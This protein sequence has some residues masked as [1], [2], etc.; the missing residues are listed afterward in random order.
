VSDADPQGVPPKD[1]LRK[2]VTIAFSERTAV[3]GFSG[4]VL[5]V[6]RILEAIKR[7]A[8]YYSSSGSLKDDLKKWMEEVI[9]NKPKRERHHLQFMLCDFHLS[10]SSHIHVYELTTDG[11]VRFQ[12]DEVFVVPGLAQVAVIGKG[13]EFKDQIHE[14]ALRSI[15]S[16]KS[17]TDYEAFSRLRAMWTELSIR[18][19]FEDLASRTI[20]GPSTVFRI[21]PNEVVGP[22]YTM[23][24]IDDSPDIQVTDNGKKTVLYSP[25][26]KKEYTLFSIFSYSDA[27]FYAYEDACAEAR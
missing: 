8:K 27:D 3:L 19:W 24:T 4:N 6:K 23:P 18:L 7:R 15:G 9:H 21:R 5:E 11:E 12:P 13:S 14:A 20:G 2:L 16:P 25:A 26:T 22:N 1:Q 17:Y 10:D